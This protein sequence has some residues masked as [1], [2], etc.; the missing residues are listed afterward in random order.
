MFTDGTRTPSSALTTDSIDMP[1]FDQRPA[2]CDRCFNIGYRIRPTGGVEQCPVIQSREPHPEITATGKMIDRSI[3]LLLF[4][5]LEVDQLHFDIARTI[6][7]WTPGSPCSNDEL[8]RRHFSW[9]S[10]STEARMKEAQR[11]HVA[12]AI[13]FL[14]EI[15]LL[16]VGS[17]KDKPSGYY[18]CRTEAEFKEYFER[19][20]REPVTEL[21]M[22]HR[23]AAANWPVFAEQLEIDFWKDFPAA[24]IGEAGDRFKDHIAKA[25]AALEFI[26]EGSPIP[27]DIG[28]VGITLPD[29]TGSTDELSR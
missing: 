24:L 3:R 15:W 9:V 7:L 2:H 4:R 5:K 23:M 22:L 18:I 1:L 29:P 8:V 13:R 17:R 25:E 16:P 10:G 28:T 27:Y 6:A 14:R 11:R 26:P 19:T 20:R 12:K 21:S